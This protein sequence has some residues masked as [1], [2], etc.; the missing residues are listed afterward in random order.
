MWV[1]AMVAWR[2]GCLW[3]ARA[4]TAHDGNMTADTFRVLVLAG[5]VL[6]VLALAQIIRLLGSIG[7]DLQAFRARYLPEDDEDM[8]LVVSQISTVWDSS[9]S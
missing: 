6:A 4:D 9:N 2:L 1:Q 5:L 8:G 7:E 3:D